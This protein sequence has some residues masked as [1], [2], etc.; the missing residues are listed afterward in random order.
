MHN[1]KKKTNLSFKSCDSGISSLY[2]CNLIVSSVATPPS[3][4]SVATRP[5]TRSGSSQFF[6][7]SGFSGLEIRPHSS[8]T[9]FRTGFESDPSGSGWIWF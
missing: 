4:S 2:I 6:W 3:I 8:I 9:K 5:D 7:I 1:Y